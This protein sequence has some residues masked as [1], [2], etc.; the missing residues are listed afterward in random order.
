MLADSHKLTQTRMLLLRRS[1]FL[2]VLLNFSLTFPTEPSS[3]AAE[4]SSILAQAFIY[5]R[6]DFL[7][8][9]NT[10]TVNRSRSSRL[11]P[12]VSADGTLSHFRCWSCS[13][14]GHSHTHNYARNSS[15]GGLHSIHFPRGLLQNREGK[16][17]TA[18]LAKKMPKKKL[19]LE[20]SV[21]VV[22][23]LS[24]TVQQGWRGSGGQI[25]AGSQ[26]QTRNPSPN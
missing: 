20:R 17:R 2:F 16:E 3:L 5:R 6:I 4:S 12:D 7:G 23:S 8:N 11:F 26:K 21:V 22:V 14:R 10:W 18:T 24:L 13:R 19:D 9:A 25:L 15:H 1:F